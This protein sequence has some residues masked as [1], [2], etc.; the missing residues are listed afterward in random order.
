MLWLAAG[1]Y[2]YTAVKQ[3]EDYGETTVTA[4]K[5]L[6]QTSTGLV[7][8]GR[9]LRE[10]GAALDDIPF[11][12]EQIDANIRRTAGDVDE[13]ARTVR[14]TARQARAAGVETRDAA[15]GLAV[16]LGLAV[17]LAPTLPLLALYLLLRPLVAQQLRR[18]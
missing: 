17:A 4:A 5:G 1:A 9:G 8:A 3:L 18:R 7:R 6:D 13:V 15:R 10:T 2:V 14:T 11:V 16:V 12:G